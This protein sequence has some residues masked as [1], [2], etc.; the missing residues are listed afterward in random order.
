MAIKIKFWFYIKWQRLVLQFRFSHLEIF[1]CLQWMY[2]SSIGRKIMRAHD[3]SRAL[4]KKEDAFPSN[5]IET[6]AFFLRI[7]ISFA[8]YEGPEW[9]PATSKKKKNEKTRSQKEPNQMHRV[10]GTNCR[11]FLGACLLIHGMASIRSLPIAI[12]AGKR[13]LLPFKKWGVFLILAL[14]I[15][16]LA[17]T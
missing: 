5:R 8:A 2:T 4:E 13:W 3:F 1:A 17:Y 15:C 9:P 12:I 6:E 11:H 10:H 7:V 14:G 16:T